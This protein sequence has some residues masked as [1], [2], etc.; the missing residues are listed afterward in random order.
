MPLTVGDSPE[1]SCLSGSA[2]SISSPKLFSIVTPAAQC[3]VF[4]ITWNPDAPQIQDGQ[5]YIRGYIPGGDAFALDKPKHGASFAEWDIDIQHGTQF[6][7]LF[8]TGGSDGLATLLE[9][10]QLYTVEGNEKSRTSCFIPDQPSSTISV[11]PTPTLPSLSAGLPV[12]SSCLS[13]DCAPSSGLTRLSG[14]TDKSVGP[15]LTSF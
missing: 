13:G 5:V 11:A 4:N 8:S 6:I 10:S 15:G 9:T 14:P 7:L 1:A 3:Q 12:T 2:Y